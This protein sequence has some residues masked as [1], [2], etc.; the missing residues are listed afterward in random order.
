MIEIWGF[1]FTL[2]FSVFCFFILLSVVVL[3]VRLVFIHVFLFCSFVFVCSFFF[4][5][6]LG[7]F[8][9]EMGQTSCKLCDQYEYPTMIVEI[10][11]ASSSHL[12]THALTHNTLDELTHESDKAQK[13]TSIAD[14]PQFIEKDSSLD[15]LFS[16]LHSFFSR[17][18][19][20]SSSSSSSFSSSSLSSI[21][22]FATQSSGPLLLCPEPESLK[23]NE[24]QAIALHAVN[25][26]LIALVCV[27]CS[28]C[29]IFLMLLYVF[30]LLVR[31]FVFDFVPSFI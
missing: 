20:S 25:S 31:A 18:S 1:N 26:C 11:S 29:G 23:L 30:V 22:S 12:H 27:V 28:V 6:H 17:V 16:P 19:S 3:R 9:D 7:T 10:S 5:A 13:Q 2:D 4:F 14:S 15:S 24:S 21:H 8:Q